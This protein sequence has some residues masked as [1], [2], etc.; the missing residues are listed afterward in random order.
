MVP[1][2]AC[3]RSLANATQP[4]DRAAIVTDILAIFSLLQPSS[5][6]LQQLERGPR[7]RAARAAKRRAIASSK[8]APRRGPRLTRP[9]GGHST[10][11]G[12]RREHQPAASSSRAVALSGATPVALHRQHRAHAGSVTFS[13]CAWSAGRRARH[14]A[15]YP[16][17]YVCCN[18]AAAFAALLPQQE[19]DPCSGAQ[20]AQLDP[21]LDRIRGAAAGRIT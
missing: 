14:T 13:E 19:S 4:K 15:D 21:Q 12:A 20:A 9:A 17:Q 1:V 18:A 8:A 2:T 11:G 16:N 7:P 10:C 5:L 3:A 6:L